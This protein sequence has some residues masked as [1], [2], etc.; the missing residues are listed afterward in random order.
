MRGLN[1]HFSVLIKLLN[2][3]PTASIMQRKFGDFRASDGVVA[4]ATM[5]IKRIIHP[6]DHI[7]YSLRQW[8][9]CPTPNNPSFSYRVPDIVFRDSSSSNLHFMAFSEQEYSVE[10]LENLP[11]RDQ[12]D[13]FCQPQTVYPRRRIEWPSIDHP[14]LNRLTRDPLHPRDET[15]KQMRDLVLDAW[16]ACGKYPTSHDWDIHEEM[17]EPHPDYLML[18]KN[19]YWRGRQ[20]L[21]IFDL[22]WLLFE[23]GFLKLDC[24]SS[25]WNCYTSG[26]S[27]SPVMLIFNQ[28]SRVKEV[29]NLHKPWFPG[30]RASGLPE[31]WLG[32]MIARAS[33]DATDKLVDTIASTGI[34]GDLDREA[35]IERAKELPAGEIRFTRQ[36]DEASSSSQGLTG[37]FFGCWLPSGL[38]PDISTYPAKVKER[39]KRFNNIECVYKALFEV[40]DEELV[41]EDDQDKYF[42]TNHTQATLV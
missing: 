8:P 17:R 22:W 11:F 25:P 3:L 27:L 14:E 33:T 13:V 5:W 9:G 28:F 18:F 10:F 36:I 30:Y 38:G 29:W 6:Y 41:L 26:T 35:L 20:Q 32:T 40:D 39:L 23:R 42:R 4:G 16:G 24:L 1:R 15:L 2:G 7:Y 12:S 34:L 19:L 21:A 31:V 37:E